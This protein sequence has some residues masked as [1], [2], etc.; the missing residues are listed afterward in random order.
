VADRR[1]G[2]RA[3]GGRRRAGDGDTRGTRSSGAWGGTRAGAAVL[4]GG[5]RAAALEQGSL[6]ARAGRPRGQG[7]AQGQGHGGTSVAAAAAAL[8]M[9]V[10]RAGRRLGWG[11][12]GGGGLDG[13]LRQGGA[14]VGQRSGRA[15]VGQGRRRSGR[16]FDRLSERRRMSPRVRGLALKRLIPVG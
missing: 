11:G 9:G 1:V 3:D 15:A 13:G 14:R 12:S 7:D 2:A 8:G 16:S 6:G 5:P 4:R 10:A